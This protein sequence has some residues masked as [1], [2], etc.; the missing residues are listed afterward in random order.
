M[1]TTLF[2]LGL[3]NFIVQ[4]RRPKRVLSERE[5]FVSRT[6]QANEVVCILAN[7]S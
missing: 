3:G 2:Y 4:V 1:N 6:T 5:A 7:P